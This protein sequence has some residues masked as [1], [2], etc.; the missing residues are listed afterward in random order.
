MKT[1]S[2]TQL[3]ASNLLDYLA[4]EL[5]VTGALPTDRTIVL[6]RFRDELGDW[7]ICLLTPFGARV[8]APWALAIEARL[9]EKLGLDV[10]PIWSDDGIVIR[11][12]MTDE[13]G[14]PALSDDGL[15]G[16]ASAGSGG[17]AVSAAEEAVRIGSEEVEELVIGALG[18]SSMFSSRFRE[19]AARALLLPR[20]RAGQR[21]PLWQ[22]RQRSAQ[23]LSVASRYGSFPI[24]LETYREC[25]QD[26][27]D[28]PALRGILAA[29]ERREIRIV[30]VETRRASPFASSLMFDYIASY[31]YEGDAPLVDRRAQALALDRDLLRELLGAEELREL[32]DADALAE[33]ELE[34]QFLTPD[35]AAG[36]ADAVHDLLRRLGDLSADEVAAR[37]R[38]QDERARE[39]AAGEWL[40]ALAADRRAVVVRIRGE[41]RWIAMEDV[42]RYRDALGIA[43]PVGVPQALL[44]ATTEPLTALLTRWSRH[45]GPFLATEPAARW[46][47]PV[48]DVEVELERLLVAGTILRGEFRPDGVEREWCH[49]DVLRLLRRRSLARLRREIEPVEPSALARFLPRWQGIGDRRTGID[50]LAEVIAQLEGTPLPASV[51][52]RDVLP[53]RVAGYSP[54]LLDELGASG[55][56]VWIGLGSLGQ[57]DGRVALYRPDRLPLLVT[58]LD[59]GDPPQPSW[60]HDVIR[61][62]LAE[63]GASFYRDLL[64]AA[65]RAAVERGER[66]V[67]ERELLD[68]LW[69]LV[70]TTEVTNDTFAPLRALRWPRTGS[71][72]RNGPTSTPRPR[73]ASTAR[74]GPPEAAGRWSL[75]K[76]AVA[77][78]VDLRGG[79]PTETERRHAQALR[80]LDAYGVVTRD[81]VAGEGLAGGFSA[82]YPVLREMEE[83][84]RVRRGYFVEGLGG[85]QF[86][87]PAALDRLRAE[88]ADASGD[89]NP[90]EA[91]ILG[92]A[93]PANP[94]GASL[95]W[96]RWS[97][98]DRRPLARAAGAY[99]V[100]IDGEPVLYL[101]RGGK[102]LQ[103]LPAFADRDTAEMA[104]SA[105]RQLVADGRFRSLQI[106]RVDGVPVGESPHAEALSLAGFQRSYRGWLLKA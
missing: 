6:Q 27:F 36:S 96:P 78:A 59:A 37:V 16:N 45:H 7:R 35:R 43:V 54:R 13:L 84:G 61:T 51:L 106:E 15:S 89:R 4:E 91:M 68:A 18:G 63:R 25:L 28:L 23:L 9:R 50:R 24:I 92:A 53:A 19:N 47:L 83:R 75:V 39:A 22:M 32:L 101:E 58:G 74:M 104:L 48:A 102:T 38:G 46:G 20:R 14:V 90:T 62:H 60:L 82:V 57:D 21:T 94:Y 72:R 29:I 5:S 31:M 77:T 34:L 8:H 64:A 49:P 2:W 93:D 30:S 55:E 103:T 70:W 73:F 10:Q 69:D 3:A 86:C 65:L 87:I 52:E 71:S 85:A 1:T 105:L 56:V 79:A 12:P 17:G 67:R 40:E 44:N 88:R 98:E 11:L 41:K 97:E 95:A 76:D 26:V 100:L 99:V 33:L 42:A 80:L 66:P 81:T